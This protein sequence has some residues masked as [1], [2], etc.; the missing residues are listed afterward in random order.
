[1]T[2]RKDSCSVGTRK[3]SGP[4]C[5]FRLKGPRFLDHWPRYGLTD[6]RSVNQSTPSGSEICRLDQP[7]APRAEKASGRNAIRYARHGTALGAVR[8]RHH[9]P[10]RSTVQ[11]ARPTLPEPTRSRGH[12]RAVQCRRRQIWHRADPAPKTTRTY[13]PLY[14]SS[15]S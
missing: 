3:W 4:Q 10:V 11:C 15:T 14:L 13:G 2:S 9:S 6:P 7:R 1:M 8:P 5:L 12:G